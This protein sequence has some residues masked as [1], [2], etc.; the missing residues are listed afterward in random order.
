MTCQSFIQ[1]NKTPGLWTA[2]AKLWKAMGPGHA[3]SLPAHSPQEPGHHAGRRH[4]ERSHEGDLAYS[5]TNVSATV[6]ITPGMRMR[7][8][9]T[10]LLTPR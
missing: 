10:S 4:A 8:L 6:S 1:I 5:P 3:L 2:E 7:G 9:Q